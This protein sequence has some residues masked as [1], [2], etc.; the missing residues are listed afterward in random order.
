MSQD[1]ISLPIY[2]WNHNSLICSIK[3]N[4]REENY[5]NRMADNCVQ[6]QNN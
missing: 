1:L 4:S 5:D 6:V 2:H 3:H